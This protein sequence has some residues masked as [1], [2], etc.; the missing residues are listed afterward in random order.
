MK[1]KEKKHVPE[2]KKESKEPKSIVQQ[3]EAKAER[4]Q[5]QN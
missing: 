3:S 4:H 5:V 1:Q 2:P